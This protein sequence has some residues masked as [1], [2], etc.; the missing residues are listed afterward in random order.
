MSA[1]KPFKVFLSDSERFEVVCPVDGC[2][3]RLNIRAQK[4]NHFHITKMN[5]AHTCC[6]FTPTITRA[7][8]F[9]KTLRFIAD[10]PKVTIPELTDSFRRSF[11]VNVTTAT[12]ER[13]LNEVHK[14]FGG[15]AQFWTIKSFLQAFVERNPGS[16]TWFQDNDGE[17]LMAFLSPAV[18]VH[19]FNNS[20][21]V[22]ALDACHVK[23]RYGGVIMALTVLDGD[24]CVFPGVLGVAESEN[25]ETWRCFLERV[26]D[27]LHI[28]NGHGVVVLSDREKGIK[29]AVR[30][31]LPRAA[32]SFCVFHIQKNVKTR[33]KTALNGLLFTAAKASTR[34]AF[35]DALEEMKKP[36]KRAGRYVKRINPTRWARPF[37]PSRRFGHVTSNMA[38]SMNHWLEEARHFD[39]VRLFCCYV[40]KLNRLFQKRRD[41]YEAMADTQLPRSVAEMLLRSVDEGSRLAVAEQT[42]VFYDVERKNDPTMTRVVDL[43]EPSCSCGF[44]REFGVPCRHLCAAILHV[45]QNL[46]DY[47]IP[48]RSLTAPREVYAGFITLVDLNDLEQDQTKAPTK[49]KKRGRPKEKRMKSA[50]EVVPKR[51]VTCSLCQKKGHNSRSCTMRQVN[52]N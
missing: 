46:N 43:S 10:R 20:T 16:T 3:F 35:E 45:G 5:Y 39:P 47:V 21:R 52:D 17:F 49:T 14:S 40:R 15:D 33:F 44:F 22:I 36:Y 13:C 24:G 7:L 48:E 23:A 27:A 2:A 29:K 18:C 4:D 12:L 1:K 9:S 25:A 38:E 11:G 32:H 30:R 51:T 19:A 8:V 6:S 28:G 31:L 26:R 42:R 34:R 37:F 41:E 50:A